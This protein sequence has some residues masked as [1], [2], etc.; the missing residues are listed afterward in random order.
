MLCGAQALL[1]E[2]GL[3]WGCRSRRPP[4]HPLLPLPCCRCL[5]S[6][7]QYLPDTKRL[8]ALHDALAHLQLPA[9]QHSALSVYDAAR[10]QPLM[11]RP[12]VDLMDGYEL[13]AAVA[14]G[15]SGCEM[16]AGSVRLSGAFRRL[17][18]KDG[19]M[20]GLPTAFKAS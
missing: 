16:V 6:S 17:W 14:V 15:P 10:L 18:W 1:S 2:K 11:P 9:P 20:L 12:I 13:A 4:S 8:V 19:G 7:L 3:L 5:V